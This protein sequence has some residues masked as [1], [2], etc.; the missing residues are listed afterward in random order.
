MTDNMQNNANTY[1]LIMQTKNR[2]LF[3]AFFPQEWSRTKVVESII[4][5]CQYHQDH[6]KELEFID[7]HNERF[8][9]FGYT[10]EGMLIKIIYNISGTIET[11][12]PIITLSEDDENE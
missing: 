12:Y 1:M 4:E 9:I 3:K 7:N 11:A 8:Q 2:H 6:R 5:A 10:K